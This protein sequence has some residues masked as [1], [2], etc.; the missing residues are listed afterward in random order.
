MNVPERMPVRASKDKIRVAWLTWLCI[1]D[2][3]YGGINMFGKAE[4][5]AQVLLRNI[6]PIPVWGTAMLLGA[7]LIWF[8]WSIQGAMLSGF[9]WA[10]TAGAALVSISVGTALSYSGPVPAAFLAGCHAMII[11][12]VTSGLYKD[13]EARQRRE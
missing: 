13:R 5:A 2:A 12:Q 6:F 4:S 10:F 9:V 1:A 11:S 8:G 3:M 7:V